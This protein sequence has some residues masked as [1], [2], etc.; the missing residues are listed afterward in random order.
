MITSSA[1]PRNFFVLIVVCQF[2]RAMDSSSQSPGEAMSRPASLIEALKKNY[3]LTYEDMFVS[4]WEK[5]NCG[6]QKVRKTKGNNKQH[7]DDVRTLIPTPNLEVIDFLC[8]NR[9]SVCYL[10]GS[11]ALSLFLNGQVPCNDFDIW[12]GCQHYRSFYRTGGS[13]GDEKR[14]GGGHQATDTTTYSFAGVTPLVSFLVQLLTKFGRE[15]NIRVMKNNCVTM[16]PIDAASDAKPIDLIFSEFQQTMSSFDLS[17]CRIALNLQYYYFVTSEND[18]TDICQKVC[19]YHPVLDDDD[20]SMIKAV[21]CH[22]REVANSGEIYFDLDEGNIEDEFILKRRDITTKLRIPKY[23]DERGFKML[24][25]DPEKDNKDSYD[26]SLSSYGYSLKNA[27]A[28]YNTCATFNPE[29]ENQDYDMNL[30]A[31]APF[32]KAFLLAK[33]IVAVLAVPPSTGEKRKRSEE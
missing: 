21:R 19:H 31:M 11:S 9:N 13:R 22:L 3:G 33:G 29:D 5:E 20:A 32:Q 7:R 8:S 28:V 2:T 27:A 24:P 12:I 16:N 4:S 30:D 25:Y 14:H 15:W 1:T 6:Y 23:R 18:L 17:V 10:A 26:W